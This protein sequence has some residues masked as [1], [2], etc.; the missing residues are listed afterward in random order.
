M[1]KERLIRCTAVL[2]IVFLGIGYALFSFP[3]NKQDTSRLLDF[4]EFYAA[5]QIVRQGLGNRLYDLR[6][7]AEF[8]LQV[9]PVHA[10]YLRPPFEALL[11]FPSRI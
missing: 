6:V 11:L 2:L 9:A 7:Q 10:F 5:G 8:Q 4:S 1:G 3:A